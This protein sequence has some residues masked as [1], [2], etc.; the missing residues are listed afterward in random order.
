MTL[1]NILDNNCLKIIAEKRPHNLNSLKEVT[2]QLS[3]ADRE[4]IIQYWKY[5]IEPLKYIS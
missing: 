1:W 5:F 2:K 3:L 4:K